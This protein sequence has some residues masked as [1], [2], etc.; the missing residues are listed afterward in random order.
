MMVLAGIPTRNV[1][2]SLIPCVPAAGMR[3]SAA[4]SVAASALVT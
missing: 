4:K 3:T 2:P 1:P